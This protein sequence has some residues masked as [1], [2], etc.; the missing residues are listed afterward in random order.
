MYDFV[1]LNIIDF[2]FVVPICIVFVVPISYK[3]FLYAL[4]AKDS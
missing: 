1:F 2:V 4:Y 3:S